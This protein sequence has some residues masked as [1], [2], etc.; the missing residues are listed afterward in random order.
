MSG[1]APGWPVTLQHE[2]VGVR[3]LRRWDAAAWVAVRVRNQ[4]WLEPWEGRPESLAPASWEQRHSASVFLA[5]HKALRR[6][7][8]SGRCLPFAV[9]Y[10]GDLVG[11]ITVSTVVRGAFDGAS[12]GYWVDERVAGRGVVPVAL[13]L[14]VDHCFR[15]VGLHRL[16]AEVRPENA[17]SLRVVAKLGFREEGLHRRLLYIDGDWRDHL[18]FAVLRE[19]AAGGVLRRYLRSVAPPSD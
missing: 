17:A 7:A 11:Q 1:S 2:R 3:P 6:E 9:T 5:M 13:A 10:D 15:E 12:V 19:E 14:V 8:R 4:R 16:E 18:C